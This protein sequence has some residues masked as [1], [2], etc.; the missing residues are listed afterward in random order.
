MSE[1]WTVLPMREVIAVFGGMVWRAGTDS[2]ETGQRK[3][4][5]TLR[6]L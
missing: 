3:V 1:R 6:P 5:V 2:P 4:T